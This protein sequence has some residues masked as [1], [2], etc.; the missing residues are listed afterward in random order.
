MNKAVAAGD[1]LR[2]LGFARDDSIG[3]QD[4]LREGAGDSRGAQDE[5]LGGTPRVAEHG[6]VRLED[7]YVGRALKQPVG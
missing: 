1:R 5:V 3:A 4:D 7:G 6:D 2:S